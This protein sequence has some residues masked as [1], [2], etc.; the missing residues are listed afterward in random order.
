ML[1]SASCHC[2]EILRQIVL[3]RFRDILW[4]RRE[5][6]E[7]VHD[8]DLV[9]KIENLL[10]SR[11]RMLDILETWMVPSDHEG[12]FNENQLQL[13]TMHPRRILHRY[14]FALVNYTRTL[15]PTRYNHFHIGDHLAYAPST[16][17][18]SGL[19][20]VFELEGNRLKAEIQAAEASGDEAES[21][22]LANLHSK[23]LLHPLSASFMFDVQNL[24]RRQA[25]AVL[26]H[27]LESHPD[28]LSQVRNTMKCLK[29]A[30]AVKCLE[31]QLV[32]LRSTFAERVAAPTRA[33]QEAESA[34]TQGGQFDFEQSELD[35][36]DGMTIVSTLAKRFASTLGVGKL[37]DATLIE[38]L[39]KFAQL[40]I[41]HMF[42]EDANIGFAAAL[43]PYLRFLPP[44]HHERVSVYLKNKCEMIY[45]LDNQLLEPK[46]SLSSE[47]KALVTLKEKL[48]LMK[49]HV[50][51]KGGKRKVADV[52]DADDDEDYQ[53]NGNNNRARGPSRRSGPSW[54]AAA[55][56][57]S[58]DLQIDRMQNMRN[59]VQGAI[60]GPKSR[61]SAN[62]SRK[63][64][65]D[66]R[67]DNSYELNQIDDHGEMNVN[68]DHD[69][70]RGEIVGSGGSMPVHRRQSSSRNML[71]PQQPRKLGTRP[72]RIA[73]GLTLEDIESPLRVLE[74]HSN[75]AHVVTALSSAG[76]QDQIDRVDDEWERGEPELSSDDD[77]SEGSDEE[78]A[79]M[80]R[81]KYKL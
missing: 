34:L 11:T 16:G 76:D 66:E 72:D 41:D 6:R 15:F 40:G 27:L 17:I 39:E 71:S 37:K 20:Y 60:D 55:A 61:T 29:D 77:N 38:A 13:A 5:G 73:T 18:V 51:S 23:D 70:E 12:E 47:L 75:R 50:K 62:A 9:E 26:C 30:D 52:G 24:N 57:V 7:Q 44:K 59:N 81:R 19:R 10:K 21:K 1:V 54:G 56:D 46:T 69:D 3:W 65:T 36:E 22:R 79:M 31:V 25:A 64:S 53:V 4:T 48:G 78:I 43:E 33:R 2:I 80:P 14:A 63:H 42:E 35:I 49:A 45:G 28:M 32:A 67:D 58:V 68:E 8:R 74:K